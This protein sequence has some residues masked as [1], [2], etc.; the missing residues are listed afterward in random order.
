M[1]QG[2]VIL[3]AGLCDWFGLDSGVHG[4]AATKGRILLALYRAS[5][6]P[7]AASELARRSGCSMGLNAQRVHAS[8]LRRVLP[9]GSL[10][11]V[12]GVTSRQSGG[13][14]LTGIGRA[15]VAEALAA[16]LAAVL[17][18]VDQHTIYQASNLAEAA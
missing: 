7:L 1:K 11:T 8:R 5:G 15:A 12:A 13:Y 4:R 6:S 3:A 17:A 16:I 10:E 18:A 14:R 9:P 2:D